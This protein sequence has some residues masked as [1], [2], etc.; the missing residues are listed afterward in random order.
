MEEMSAPRA[1]RATGTTPLPLVSKEHLGILN[2]TAF[3]A[4]LATLVVR[5]TETIGVLGAVCLLL[6]YE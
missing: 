4:G 6:E 3:S 1:L 2:G 5:N